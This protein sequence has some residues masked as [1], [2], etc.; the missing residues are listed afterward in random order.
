M[1][2]TAVNYTVSQQAAVDAANRINAFFHHGYRCNP[3]T[4]GMPMTR[5]LV[6]EVTQMV[7]GFVTTATRDALNAMGNSLHRSMECVG[8]DVTPEDCDFMSGITDYYKSLALILKGVPETSDLWELVFRVYAAMAAHLGSDATTWVRVGVI[9]KTLMARLQRLF[10]WA[11]DTGLEAKYPGVLAQLE[12]AYEPLETFVHN[13]HY[14]ITDQS[15]VPPLLQEDDQW[16]GLRSDSEDDE[17]D[18]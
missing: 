5:S 18:M 11:R 13:F 4:V 17:D 7:E 15:N 14:L 3:I 8:H 10:A 6:K 1:P 2:T 16:D 9:V 12:F